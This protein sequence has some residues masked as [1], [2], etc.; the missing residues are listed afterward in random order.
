M[1]KIE[2]KAALSKESF[3]KKKTL[4]TVSGGERGRQSQKYGVREEVL[5]FG[6]LKENDEN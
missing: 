2:H 3:C 6:S 1:S 5:V 4:L